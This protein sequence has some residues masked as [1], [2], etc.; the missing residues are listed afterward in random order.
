MTTISEFELNLSYESCDNVFDGD[1]VDTVF[2]NFLS[3][4]LRIF[5]HTFPL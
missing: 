2:N 1:D 3:T 5:Y 4:Y